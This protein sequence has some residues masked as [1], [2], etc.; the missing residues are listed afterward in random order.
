MHKPHTHLPPNQHLHGH[1]YHAEVP[2]IYYK[3]E[4]TVHQGL[5]QKCRD[6]VA[7]ELFFHE[8]TFNVI[9]SLYPCKPEEA[10]YLAAIHLRMEKGPKASKSDMGLVQSPRRRAARTRSITLA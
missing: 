5:E 1:A 8:M 6:P 3:R 4:A 10:A 2:L 7:I 9:Y